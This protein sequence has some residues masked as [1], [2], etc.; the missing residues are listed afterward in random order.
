MREIKAYKD[1]PVFAHSDGDLN[2]VMHK[3][4]ELG[5]DG[6]QSLQ[7]SANMDIAQIKREYGDQ[8]CLWGNIDLNYVM[9]FASPE[10][11]KRVVQ[12]IISIAGDNGGFILSTCNSMVDCIPPE[13]VLAMMEA[14]ER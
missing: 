8:L 13:N 1:V 2:S 7:P 6:I 14:A 5:F 9:C 4:V 10:E 11:V 12:E 3:Y